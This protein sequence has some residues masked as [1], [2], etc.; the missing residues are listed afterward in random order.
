MAAGEYSISGG[1]VPVLSP[2]GSSLATS[3]VSNSHLVTIRGN[4]SSPHDVLLR[5]SH[6]E[7]GCLAFDQGT[8]GLT[9]SGLTLNITGPAAA[10]S[11][12]IF[13]FNGGYVTVV[14]TVIVGFDMGVVVTG[15][16]QI[17]MF[18]VNIVSC[19][20]GI[21]SFYGGQALL[22]NVAITDAT[23]AGL[24]AT[25]GGQVNAAGV[26]VACSSPSVGAGL[27]AASLALFQSQAAHWVLCV[28]FSGASRQ[29]ARSVAALL[30][31]FNATVTIKCQGSI[32]RSLPE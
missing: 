22:S 26:A 24:A 7:S 32:C 13:V 1:L 12:G 4:P 17:D 23:V 20:A 5:C 14:D 27:A 2:D 6:S 21:R 8:R 11:R 30:R 16:G 28:L 31:S 29:L 18:T 15:T 3:P 10:V 25:T 19:S 9:L